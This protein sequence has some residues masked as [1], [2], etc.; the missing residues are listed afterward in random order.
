MGRTNITRRNFLFGKG[1]EH[2]QSDGL[3]DDEVGA[4]AIEYGLIG[5]LIAVGLIGAL[6]RTGKRTRRP[7]NCVKATMRNARRGGDTPNCAK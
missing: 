4:A 1:Q 7:L 5:G 3:I 6:T 2:D